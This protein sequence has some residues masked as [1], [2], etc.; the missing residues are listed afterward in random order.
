MSDKLNAAFT[1]L[2]N[3]NNSMAL[4]F[5]QLAEAIDYQRQ[6][7][8][9]LKVKSVL[10]TQTVMAQALPTTPS[11]VETAGVG[12]TVEIALWTRG[13]R[14]SGAVTVKD[15]GQEAKYR[16]MLFKSNPN[17]RGMI[18][19]GGVLP[20]QNNGGTFKENQVGGLFVYNNNN[21]LTISGTIN[22]STIN[23][24]VKFTGDLSSVDNRPNDNYPHFKASCSSGN[25]F[26]SVPV[27]AP[28]PT[29]QPAEGVNPLS[30][31]ASDNVLSGLMSAP[32][33]PA[34]PVLPTPAVASNPDLLVESTVDDIRDLLG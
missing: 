17:E 14:V 8:E 7:F 28:Q 27:A 5:K 12:C 10:E 25:K 29:P 3:A 9:L 11:P 2:N 13:E 30:Q 23:H 18:L 6:A 22:A 31:V 34:D 21:K 33:M 26:F 20:E 15:E 24:E 4:A 32:G 16:C 1:L 19:N